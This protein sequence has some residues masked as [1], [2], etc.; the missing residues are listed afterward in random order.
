MSQPPHAEW[1]ELEREVVARVAALAPEWTN[2][3]DSDPGITLLKLFEF[4]GESL[5]ERA[6]RIPE[7]RERVRDML[8]RLDRTIAPGCDDVILTRNRYF[9]GKLLSVDDFNAEQAYGRAKQRRHNRLV[10]GTGIVSGLH[11]TLDPCGP[12]EAKVV[13]SPGVAIG[14]DGEELVVCDPETREVRETGSVC[15]VTVSLVE[16]PA[17]P[18]PDGEWSRIEESAAVAVSTT[19][20]GDHLAIARLVRDGSDAAWRIDPGFTPKGR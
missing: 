2:R 3:S 6:N 5:L 10:H 11:V 13:V 14:P 8:V 18:V 7:A 4:L 16:R 15:Y 1:T 9:F 20:P 17:E 12:D 19:V